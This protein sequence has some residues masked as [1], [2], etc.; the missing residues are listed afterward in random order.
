MEISIQKESSSCMG[1][2]TPFVHEQNHLSL[3]RIEEKN[4]L[5]EDYCEKC[6]SER[7]AQSESNDIYSFWETKYRDPSVEKATPHEQFVPLL[8]LCYESIAHGEPADEAM[9]YMCALILR[10]Q[11]VFRFIREGKD[12]SS[13]KDILVFSDKHNGTQINIIDPHLTESQ[14]QEVK[15]QLEERLGKSRGQI[16][17]QESGPA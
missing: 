17:D 7:F 13:G 5:R 16:D 9:A 11:K 6:W 1:C 3:L 12:D 8:N 4:F 15:H 2:D 10:R 14:L